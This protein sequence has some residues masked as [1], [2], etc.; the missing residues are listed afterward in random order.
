MAIYAVVYGALIAQIDA[1][2]HDK[3]MPLGEALGIGF[4]RAPTMLGV[5]ILV[6]FLV[7]LGFVLLIIPGIWLWGMFQL[8]IL[9]PIVERTGAYASMETSRRLIKGN[10]WR[11]NITVFVAFILVMVLMMVVSA[12]AGIIVGIFSASS[13]NLG[14]AADAA[15]AVAGAAASFQLAQQILSAVVNLFTM[16]FLPSVMLCVYYDLKLRKEGADLAERVGTLN[17]SS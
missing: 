5:F 17:P 16:T 10:W 13:A 15:A 6:G 12:V 2:A 14:D 4:A 7:G 11:A 8:S 1:M 3:R 9:P